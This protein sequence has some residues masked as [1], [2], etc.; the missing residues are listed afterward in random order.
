MP[1]NLKT[2]PNNVANGGK[3]FNA[4]PPPGTDASKYEVKKPGDTPWDPYAP[5]P[6]GTDASKYEVKKPGDTPWDPYAPP[7]PGTDASKYEVK[8]PGDTPWDPYAPPPPGTDA[9]KYEV[10]KPGDTPWDPYAPPPPGSSQISGAHWLP[11]AIN[12]LQN[13]S[14]HQ[15]L[16][17]SPRRY[18]IVEEIPVETPHNPQGNQS[19]QIYFQQPTY[20]TSRVQ[21]APGQ[22]V[23]SVIQP[24][25][26]VLDSS[27]VRPVNTLTGSNIPI[28][29]T[30]IPYPP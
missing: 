21:L 26:Y 6:P 20:S 14:E 10:K 4:S 29:P 13:N 12:H 17:P 23:Y 3:T 22:Q 11:S 16:S 24:G 15:S 2:Q 8:K 7:P 9:S 18:K 25:S 19:S 1:A 30:L 27:Q 5:P 28:N